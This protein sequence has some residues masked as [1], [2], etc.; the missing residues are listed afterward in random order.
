MARIADVRTAAAALLLLFAIGCPAPSHRCEQDKH[1][2]PGRICVSR[3]CQDRDG[4][5]DG[6]G[7]TAVED[8]ANLETGAP[9]PGRDAATEEASPDPTAPDATGAE[10][11]SPPLTD[12]HGPDAPSA[13]ADAPAAAPPAGT[14]AIDFPGGNFWIDTYE[15]SL[16]PN[17]TLGSGSLDLDGD[18]K[19]ADA[20]TAAAHARSHGMEFDEDPDHPGALDP[21]EAGVVLT[22]AVAMSVPRV[23]P[24]VNV[25]FWHAAAA[26]ANAGK[27]LCTAAE[28][29]WACSGAG[30]SLN[31]TY[32]NVFDGGDDRSTDCRTNNLNYQ[33]TGSGTNCVSPQGV[34]DMS[35]NIEEMTDLSAGLVQ[36]RGGWAYGPGD[37]NSCGTVFDHDPLTGNGAIGFR[38]CRDR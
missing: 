4:G 6:D 13:P 16:G 22:T 36:I 11:A 17:G 31:Y 2:G 35:G 15:A 38:C 14:V 24:K 30:M 12:A 21:K 18:G 8:A 19:I 10:A 34:Y 25:T 20:K 26:C 28:W 37:A 32:G 27:R 9:G 5:S 29:K 3:L 33:T 1:C 23:M 7:A